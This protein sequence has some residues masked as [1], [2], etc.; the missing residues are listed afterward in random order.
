MKYSGILVATVAVGA[1]TGVAAP[2]QAKTVKHRVAPKASSQ[3][4]E[5]R[6]LR[7]EL[8]ALKSR[9]DAQE[10]AQVQT[11][12]TAQQAAAAVTQARTDAAQAQTSAV[13]A[14]QT[15][16]K[17]DKDTGALAKAV[18]WAK[19]TKISGRMYFNTSYI[20]HEVN[21]SKGALG[22]NGVGFAVKR[23]YLGIDHR[24][25]DTFSAN[26]TMDVD[27]LLRTSTPTGTTASSTVQG[28]YIKKAFL[29]AKINPALIVRLGAADLPWIPYVENVYGYR[30]IEQTLTDRDKLDASADWGVHVLGDLAGGLVSY[31]FSAVNGSGYR[32]PKNV[33]TIDLEGRISTKYKGF[34]AAVGGYVGK[35][36]A[37]T[38]TGLPTTARL[39]KRIDALLA[40]KGTVRNIPFTIGGEYAYSENKNPT[41]FTPVIYPASE[42]ADGYSVFASVNWLPKWST[43]ARYDTLKSSEVTAYRFKHEYYNV[44]LQWSPAKIVDLALVYKHEGAHGGSIT[45]GNDQYPVGCVPTVA[46]GACGKGTFDEIGL[47]GQFRF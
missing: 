3:A 38:Q 22:D 13:T 16:A 11:A 26:L 47:Y 37:D 8:Q 15:A 6:E 32:V 41:S 33:Q 4:E 19:D 7:A 31:Q 40:Y 21:G 5:I 46:G 28:F 23:F 36:G 20:D 29:Q 27:N 9:L 10:S 24:F 39:L 43:F 18:E 17:A 1:L 42:K 30:H 35:A 34:E 14:Q 2:A 25:N 45:P 12:A 44:G